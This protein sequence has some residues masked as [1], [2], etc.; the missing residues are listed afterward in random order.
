MINNGGWDE[1]GI[2]M[3]EFIKTFKTRYHHYI[4]H[5]FIRNT[6]FHN[7]YKYTTFIICVYIQYG[8]AILCLLIFF[9]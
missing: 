3:D 1:G 9:Q 7:N 8:I 5:Y 6:Y 2:W 4:L